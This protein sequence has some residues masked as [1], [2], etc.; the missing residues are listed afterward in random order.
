MC[1]AMLMSRSWS[2]G[3]TWYW[4]RHLA[5][6]K[7]RIAGFSVGERALLFQAQKNRL[8]EPV[9]VSTQNANQAAVAMA[10]M[11]AFRRLL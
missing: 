10:L 3:I 7:A 5:G 2:I 4:S 1:S 11:C 8:N 9:F 6:R